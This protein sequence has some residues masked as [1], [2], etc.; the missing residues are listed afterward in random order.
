MRCNS[1]SIKITRSA[2]KLDL[3]TAWLDVSLRLVV[4][5][6][7]QLK[8]T[9]YEATEP[10]KD[11]IKYKQVQVKGGRKLTTGVRNRQ[12]LLQ[13]LEILFYCWGI[14]RKDKTSRTDASVM[15][16]LSMWPNDVLVMSC[17]IW[18]DTRN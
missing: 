3:H 12:R 9:I 11:R 10:V 15:N 1:L 7:I 2:F 14:I 5:C 18:K 16:F 8:E 17:C 13:K 4:K 6:L